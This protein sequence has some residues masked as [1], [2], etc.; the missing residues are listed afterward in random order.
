MKKCIVY[1]Y[2]CNLFL[3][4]VKARMLGIVVLDNS[5]NLKL[6]NYFK[7]IYCS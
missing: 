5:K 4:L 2:L 7:I 1:S 3:D 6:P